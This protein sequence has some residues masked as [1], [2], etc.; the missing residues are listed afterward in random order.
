[1]VKNCKKRK[2]VSENSNATVETCVSMEIIEKVETF[3]SKEA[4]VV[5]C[6]SNQLDT[7]EREQDVQH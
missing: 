3:A 4:V 5:A 1:M 2:K 7:K 6:Q